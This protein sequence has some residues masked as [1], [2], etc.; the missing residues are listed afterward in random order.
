MSRLRMRHGRDDLRR[1]LAATGG[2]GRKVR[3]IVALLAPYRRQT[4]LMFVALVLGTAAGLAPAPLAKQA[5]DR[6]ITRGDTGALTLIVVLFIVSAL[7][8]WVT[9]FAQTYLTN[10]VGQR[11]LQDLRLDVFRH[12]QEMPVGFYE[13]RPAGV[14]ISRLT[15]DVEALEQMVTDAVTTLFQASLTLVGSIVILLLFDVELALL[16]FLIFPV[17]AIGS[18]AF[19]LASAD[20]FARTRETI[21]SLTAYLQES[22]SGIRVLKTFA[23]EPRHVDRFAELNAD[24]RHANMATVNLNA[25]YFPAVEFVSSVATVGILLYGGHQVLDGDVTVGVLVGFIA[26]LN[27]FFDPISQLSQVYTTYQSGMAALDKIFALLDEEPDLVDAPDA[28]DLPRPLR[29][30]MEF[31]AVTFSYSTAE[32]TKTALEDISLH[33]PPGQ[34]VALVGETGAGKSTLAKLAARFY[35]PTSGAVRVDGH[36][37]R[38]VTM[39][40]LRSQMGIVPQEGFLFSGT[41]R[42]NIAF[43]VPEGV[44]VDDAVLERACRA[45]GAWEFIGRLEHGLDT[46]IGERGVQL[47]AGQRQLV[48]FA[49]AL[50]A[51]PRILVLDE[52]TS[53][54]D[55]RTETIIEDG[56]RR[57]L[58]GRTAIVI[59]HRLSTIRQAGRIVVLEHGRIVESGTHDELLAAQGHYWSLYRDW[60][61]QAAA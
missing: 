47:S 55:L 3:G 25:A 45:V 23:Q 48:A 24:N 34:T 7:V 20:A 58:A 16:T 12:L 31:D 18:F 29:G 56:L 33:I 13:R 61:E 22:L 38:S 52:A 11:A 37:L 44:E 9:S 36:D 50:V 59:A 32:G 6:G 43:G 28:V 39:R 5:I 2:R 35:D 40:S 27:G 26:A 53:N 15:N 17:M 1:R 21:G 4:A 46:Q 42:E 57:L 60:A 51:D 30:E 49:R 54:V 19:R 14:L 10:W 41:L 8:V